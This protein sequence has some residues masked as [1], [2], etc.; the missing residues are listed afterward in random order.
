[1]D[2]LKGSL[3]GF[4]RRKPLNLSKDFFTED[5]T[6]HWSGRY[7]TLDLSLTIG[8][9]S[10]KDQVYLLLSEKN[11]P[12]YQIFLHDPNFF[13]FNDNPVAF[14]MEVRIFQTGRSNSHCFRLNLIQMNELNV[15]SDPCNTDPHFDFRTCVKESVAEKVFPPELK[16]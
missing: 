15:P 7:Y 12:K 10:E 1:M 2:L 8:P 4:E 6:Q 11:L 3:L 16:Q 5:S 9:D 13:I 14:P